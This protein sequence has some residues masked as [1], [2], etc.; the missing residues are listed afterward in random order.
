MPLNQAQKLPNLVWLGLPFH[1]LTAL[2][3][4][5]KKA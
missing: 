1:A 4:E 3:P 2:Y 5:L